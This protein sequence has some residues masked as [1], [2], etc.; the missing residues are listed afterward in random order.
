MRTDEP[1]TYRRMSHCGVGGPVDPE[2]EDPP[3]FK[4]ALQPD[5]RFTMFPLRTASLRTSVPV[6]SVVPTKIT[7]ATIRRF[8]S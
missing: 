5:R 8:P 6:A 2:I 4:D 3:I 7:K 1:K